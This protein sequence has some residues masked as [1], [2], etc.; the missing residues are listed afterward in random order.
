MAPGTLSGPLGQMNCRANGIFKHR[1][2]KCNWRWPIGTTSRGGTLPFPYDWNGVVGSA[3]FLVS[4]PQ[5]IH[6]IVTRNHGCTLDGTSLTNATDEGQNT[7]FTAFPN[8]IS[9]L[10]AL[11]SPRGLAAISSMP[12]GVSSCSL[13]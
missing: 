9:D 10:V 1:W 8:P 12:K 3:E 13:P 5:D 6:W 2:I 11:E 7:P 4:E